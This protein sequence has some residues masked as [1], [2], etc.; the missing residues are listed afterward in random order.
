[1]PSETYCA[2]LFDPILMSVSTVREITLI[3]AL[4]AS[5]VACV[6]GTDDRRAG[7]ARTARAPAPAVVVSSTDRSAPA[8]APTFAAGLGTPS[9]APVRSNGGTASST[10]VGVRSTDDDRVPAAA[11]IGGGPRP[12]AAPAIAGDRADLVAGSDI[13]AA[14]VLRAPASQTRPDSPAGPDAPTGS[15]ARPPA[16][17]PSRP[18]APPGR[19]PGQAAG[20]GAAAPGAAGPDG[21]AGTAQATPSPV[22]TLRPASPPPP[23]PRIYPRPS[24][25]LNRERA[26]ERASGFYGP[27]SLTPVPP[28][29]LAIGQTEAAP[30]GASTRSGG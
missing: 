11:A 13:A 20:S 16:T 6:A 21:Q 25:P 2:G 12:A 9:S 17:K 8:T 5:L 19:G 29:R 27:D 30:V 4:A 18:A 3:A 26:G 1:M 14:R 24:L 22:P 23:W 15:A 7:E 10:T 28:R